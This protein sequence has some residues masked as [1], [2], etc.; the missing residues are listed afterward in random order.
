MVMGEAEREM[1]VSGRKGR[2]ETNRNMKNEMK[3]RQK[4]LVIEEAIVNFL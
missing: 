4:E 1:L 2:R 3:D